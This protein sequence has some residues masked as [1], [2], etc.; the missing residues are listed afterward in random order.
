MIKIG[1]RGAMGHASENSLEGFAKALAFGVA[2]VELDVHLSKDG[3]L[4]VLHDATIDRTTD[5]KGFVG[6]FLSSELASFG[7]PTLDDVVDLVAK[8]CQINIELK[9]I[10]TAEKVVNFIEKRVQEDDFCYEDFLVSSFEFSFLEEVTR[11][12]SEILIGVLTET[13]LEEALEFAE[14]I[15]A[16]SIHPDFGLLTKENTKE[17]VNK[18]FLVFPWTVNKMED[19]ERMKKYKVNGIISDYPDRI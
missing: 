14:K 17:I 19:I 18:G 13:S 12:N 5:F 11:E 8:R 15:K 3:V 16:F 4:V 9:G 7:I 2:A 6:D 10:G 1:H